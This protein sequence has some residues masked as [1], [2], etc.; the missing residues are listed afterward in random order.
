MRKLKWREIVSGKMLVGRVS[1]KNRETLIFPEHL[2][3]LD[4]GPYYEAGVGLE[5]IFKIFRVDAMWRLSYLDNPN[6][7]RFGIRGTI[8]VIF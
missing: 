6:I 3:E 7:S 4:R 8:Q 1:D 5:N 2:Y